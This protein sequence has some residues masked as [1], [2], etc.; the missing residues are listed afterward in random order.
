MK[1]HAE[2]DETMR[3][4]Y[5]LTRRWDERPFA[6]FVGMNPSTATEKILDP[7]VR[8]CVRFAQDWGFGGLLML[9]LFAY[10][11]PSIP[12]LFNARLRG[13]DIIGGARNSLEA[14]QGYI[15]KYEAGI[16]I[17]AWGVNA[18]ERGHLALEKISRLHALGWNKDHSPKHP[19]YLRADLKPINIL[20]SS[21]L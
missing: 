11:T 1:G 4:R 13:Q 5:V 17:A 9:N 10:R 16:V 7:T 3:Y 19:L 14:I 18:G 15:D 21:R 8:R 20:G 6:C 2:F 12:E